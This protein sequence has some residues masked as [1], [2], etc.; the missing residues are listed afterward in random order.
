[1]SEE[2]RAAQLLED[3][4][5][6]VRE[7]R[8]PVCVAPD[9]DVASIEA[10]I[11]PLAEAGT[12]TIDWLSTNEGRV[13]AAISGGG[14]EW[15]L[16]LVLDDSRVHL[17]EL[18]VHKRPE[19]FAGVEGGRAIVVNGPS[20]AGKSSLMEAVL[21]VALTPWVMFDEPELGQVE[22]V[23]RIWRDAAPTL[24][25]GYFHAIGALAAA[26]N[27]VT[28]SSGGFSFASVS[29]AFGAVPTVY[30]GLDCPLA[31]LLERERGREGRW[32]GLAESS[33][34]VHEGWTYDLRFDSAAIRSC[35]MAHATL[36]AVAARSG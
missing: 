20:G 12:T 30:V 23:Y 35:E 16:V 33:L 25:P 14:H 18:S 8:R 1:M 15:R 24:G 19:V 29:A 36:E 9:A 11:V 10:L 7:G 21:R 4:V 3:L 6:A 22:P 32:A 34:G 17:K 31:V 26:G 13:D 28:V 2:M 27:Q 5:D